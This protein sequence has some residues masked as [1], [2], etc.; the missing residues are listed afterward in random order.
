MPRPSII[1]VGS[2][3]TDMIVKVDRLPASGETILGGEFST[4]S[5]GKG[6][7]Q[8]VA[9]ARAGGEVTFIARVGSDAFGQAA[10]NVLRSSG[11]KADHVVTD[12]TD[13]S[14]VAL[15]FVA[16][17]GQNSIAVAP[18]ANRGLLPSD[19][20]KA[21]DAFRGARVVLLQLE[22]PPATAEA[23]ARLGKSA[24]AKVILNPA[25]AQELPARLLRGLYLIT[26]NEVEASLL[27]GITVNSEASAA[28]AAARL[29]AM[30][31]ENV[32]ITMGS[33]GALLVGPGIS[34]FI[35]AH[36]VKAVDATGAGDVFNGCLAVAIA[37]GKTL[38]QAATF[39]NAAAALSVTKLG[40]QASAPERKEVDQFIAKNTPRGRAPTALSNGRN[41]HN[42][43][44]GLSAANGKKPIKI[45][46]KL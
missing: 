2:S 31:V 24:G 23:A 15:I 37:E 20:R 45:L 25:P 17:S 19:V 28:K 43:W 8:A 27:T 35:P 40:A 7:N 18:G 26:P 34:Q 29:L 22:T 4:A 12:E 42:G 11:V 44:N 10:L 5:G 32:I 13:S 3:N 9:A 33:R 46:S 16:K 1:V 6:A 30:G 14:G 21:K 36:K 38:L 39:A 41:G